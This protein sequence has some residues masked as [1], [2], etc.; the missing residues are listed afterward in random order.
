MTP[1]LTLF[2][3]HKMVFRMRKLV[4]GLHEMVFGLHKMVFRLHKMVFRLHIMVF[5]LHKM[6]FGLLS[7]LGQGPYGKGLAKG[8]PS[9]KWE[10]IFPPL[11][12]LLPPP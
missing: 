1:K 4:F 3:H 10:N 2:G 8:R 7:G 6:V 5:G 9:W 11:M 12:N